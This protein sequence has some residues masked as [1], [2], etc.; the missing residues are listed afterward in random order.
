MS[1]VKAKD[2]LREILILKKQGYSWRKIG[3][4]VGQDHAACVRKYKRFERLLDKLV[5]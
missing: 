1:K 4:I 5:S 2:N 3:D